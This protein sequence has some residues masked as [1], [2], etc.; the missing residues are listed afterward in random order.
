M[1]V[2]T[3]A[4]RICARLQECVGLHKQAARCRH[5]SPLFH[6][7]TL[8]RVAEGALPQHGFNQDLKRSQ[9]QSGHK[10]VQ[11]VPFVGLWDVHM[12]VSS[13]QR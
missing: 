3:S 11:R 4:S 5:G 1:L 9:K 8:E 7:G 13:G 2:F 10:H 6:T 12:A